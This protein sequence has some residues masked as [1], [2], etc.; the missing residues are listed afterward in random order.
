MEVRI[1]VVIVGTGCPSLMFSAV[2][3][4]A[5]VVRLGLGFL[6]VWL[7]PG[8]LSLTADE[9]M[10]G[11]LIPVYVAVQACI[12]GGSA[13]GPA[14]VAVRRVV[15][16]RRR[17]VADGAAAAAAA[18]AALQVISTLLSAGNRALCHC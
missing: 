18:A 8:L 5:A 1:T 2:W 3:A 12:L 13:S 14:A 17:R 11:P 4:L 9:V 10:L 7:I 16:R 15:V 6:S